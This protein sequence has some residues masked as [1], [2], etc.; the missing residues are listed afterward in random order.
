MR[1]KLC[2]V[3]TTAPSEAE[4]LRIGEA[5]LQARLAACVQYEAIRSQYYW[6]GEF[7]DEAEVRLVIK[8]ARACFPEVEAL[9]LRLHAYDCPQILALPVAAVSE[10]YRQWL[11]AS[12]ANPAP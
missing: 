1:D 8:T 2:L 12:V 6:Q 4:A 9:I 3:L 7:C 5:F 10:G 11:L